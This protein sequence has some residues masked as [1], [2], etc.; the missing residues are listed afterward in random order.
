MNIFSVDILLS[1]VD[2]ILILL[3]LYRS[4]NNAWYID[5]MLRLLKTGQEILFIHKNNIIDQCN[6]T[7]TQAQLISAAYDEKHDAKS[8]QQLKQFVTKLPHMQ[9]ERKSLEIQT[10][11][12]GL[13]SVI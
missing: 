2:F 10:A 13:V 8:L 7:F 3:K 11:I 9:A 6:N 12:A 4:K 1:N 5:F